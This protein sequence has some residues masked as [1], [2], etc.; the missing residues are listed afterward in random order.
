[1]LRF[2]RTHLPVPSAWGLVP[3]RTSPRPAALAALA[4]AVLLSALAFSAGLPA[5]AGLGTAAAAPDDG[6]QAAPD[7][8]PREVAVLASFD[9]FD[10]TRIDAEPGE[11]LE[12]TFTVI[13]LTGSYDLVFELDGGRTERT[14]AIGIGRVETLEFDAPAEPGLYPYY[15]SVGTTRSD[16]YD[17]VLVVG[18]G[19]PLVVDAR[20]FSYD[21]DVIR[22]EPGEWVQIVLNNVQGFHDIVFELDG[23]RVEATSRISEGETEELLFRAPEADGAFPYYCSVGSHRLNGMEGVFLV[24]DATPPPSPTPTDEP[25][26]GTPGTPGSPTPTEHAHPTETPTEEPTEPAGYPVVI[27]DLANPHGLS[28]HVEGRVLVAEGGTGE[29]TPGEFAPGNGDG[30]VL[31]IALADPS[32]RMTLIADMTNALDPAGGV[33]GANHAISMTG[34][35]L[36]AQA[37]GPGHLR[38]EEAAK[39]LKLVPGEAPAV[40]ADTLAYETENNPDGGEGPAGIDSNPW[41]L[42]PGPSGDPS[43]YIV[44]AGA[45]AILRMNP[46]TGEL[47]TWAV[48]AP[49]DEAGAQQ[50]IP[51]GLAFYESEVPGVGL[52]ALVTLLGGFAPPGTPDYTSGQVRLLFD[53]NGDGDV[54][55]EDENMLLLDDVYLPTDIAVDT[56]DSKVFIAELGRS[57]VAS[58]NTA[59]LFTAMLCV[60]AGGELADCFADAGDRYDGVADGVPAVTAL[61]LDTDGSVLATTTGSP[62]PMAANVNPDRIIRLTVDDFEPE[63]PSPEPTEPGPTPTEPGPTPTDEPEPTDEPGGASTIYLAFATKNA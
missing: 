37:G 46:D 35:S 15:S 24:G 49:L 33:V 39:I 45:N 8:T 60:F 29:A 47:G 32:E 38:P 10:P 3:S 2:L 43:V 53:A 13:A 22:A 50:A 18:G 31:D 7:Q 61:A 36:V 51:T 44:D 63:E 5:G 58:L 54:L 1:M 17:G 41:R 12:V 52:G 28:V 6:P 4:A 11:A 40:L 57:R 23:G 34:Y 48:F 19:S 42:V 56:E 62:I 27:D 9:G 14:P 30:R 26:P 55:D 16:G 59:G 20:N 25:E 21:P